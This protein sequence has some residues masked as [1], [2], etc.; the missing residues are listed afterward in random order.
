MHEISPLGCDGEVSYSARAEDCSIL[1]IVLI[2]FIWNACIMHVKMERRSLGDVGFDLVEMPGGDI[3]WYSPFLLINGAPV[4]NACT[5]SQ[6]NFLSGRR[7][8]SRVVQRKGSAVGGYYTTQESS[9]R[10]LSA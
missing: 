5:S 8:V 7:F 10:S 6:G 4:W 1:E 3:C 2:A 9:A